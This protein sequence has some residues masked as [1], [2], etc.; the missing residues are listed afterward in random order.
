MDV[1][2]EDFFAFCQDD[3]VF[4]HNASFDLRMLANACE[5]AAKAFTNVAGGAC[6]L[7]IARA[8]WPH[9]RSHRLQALVRYTGASMPTHQAIDDVHALRHVLPAARIPSTKRRDVHFTGTRFRITVLLS[10]R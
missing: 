1:A 6:T 5:R 3:P 2:L 7:K 10:S 9:L 4:F 8:A